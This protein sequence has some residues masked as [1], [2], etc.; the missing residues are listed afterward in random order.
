MNT[1]VLLI[2]TFWAMGMLAWFLLRKD[3]DGPSGFA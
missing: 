1:T 3:D 2:A